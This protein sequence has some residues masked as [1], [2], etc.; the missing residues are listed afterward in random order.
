MSI[1]N[2]INYALT[3]RRRSSVGKVKFPKL[4]IRAA[5]RRDDVFTPEEHELMS[6]MITLGIVVVCVLVAVVAVAVGVAGLVVDV[7]AGW[8]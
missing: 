4:A 1:V 8:K 2:A 5:L 6:D 3:A 7:V